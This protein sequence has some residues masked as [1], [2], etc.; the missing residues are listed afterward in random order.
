MLT[1]P[2]VFEVTQLFDFYYGATWS[3]SRKNL[4][5]WKEVVSGDFEQKVK[6][7]FDQRRFLRVLQDYIIFLSKDD[8]LTKVILRQ[9]QVQAIEKVV[10][11]V[12]EGVKQHGLIWHTQGSGKTLTMI[13]IAARLLQAPQGEKPTVIMIVDRNELESQLF[14]NIQAYG[15]NNVKVANSKRDLQEILILT[16]AAW[17]SPWSTSSIKFAPEQYAQKYCCPGR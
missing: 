6:N 17:S 8:I 9:H 3:T 4:F 2:Q 10:Q 16:I 15:I 11:R 1:I 5:N 14:K 7:F 13:T 12:E